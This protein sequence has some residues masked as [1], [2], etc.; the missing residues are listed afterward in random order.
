MARRGARDSGP[1][2]WRIKGNRSTKRITQGRCRALPRSPL[3]Q[4]QRRANPTRCSCRAA[5]HGL[6][7]FHVEHGL[8]P[9]E[10]LAA[11]PYALQT[12]GL[13]AAGRCSITVPEP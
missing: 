9:H 12:E 11:N 10:G 3:Q 2:E 7:A 6:S 4:P 13:A 1:A 5:G 8:R